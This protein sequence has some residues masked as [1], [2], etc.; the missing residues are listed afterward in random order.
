MA[1]GGLLLAAVCAGALGWIGRPV[2]VLLPDP[3]D[4]P[5]HAPTNRA[6][7]RAPRL[8]WWLSGTAAALIVVVTLA[9]PLFVLPAWILVCGVGTWLSYIDWHTRRL[10]LHLMAP[11]WGTTLVVVLLEAWLASDVGILL[12]ALAS[13]AVAA[14]LYWLVAWFT[15]Q[16]RPGT[17]GLDDVRFAALVG[18]VSGSVG[19]EAAGAGL[20][21]GLVVAAAIRV[22]RRTRDQDLDFAFAPAILAG[23]V[24]GLLFT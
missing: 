19:F 11:L 15:A 12:R 8:C 14:G 5:E 7:S 17:F 22:V 21:L 9:A 20:V 3:A 13:S 2:L 24:L 10:P 6:I 16:R 18:L 1:L 23:A 4:A